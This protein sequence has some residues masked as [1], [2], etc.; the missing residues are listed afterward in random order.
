MCIAGW[1]IEAYRNRR[2]S[3]EGLGTACPV[4]CK[5][6]KKL[7]LIRLQQNDLHEDPIFYAMSH[8]FECESETEEPESSGELE[9]ESWEVPA[10]PANSVPANV[11][12]STSGSD[13]SR[14]PG[15]DS[16]GSSSG[17]EV[18]QEQMLA[19][20]AENEDIV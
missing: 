1:C 8:A 10:P 5:T 7:G 3:A 20:E 6:I 4:C 11:G 2:T 12:N 13:S 14:L 15:T 17:F 16:S 9:E 19:Y 18:T